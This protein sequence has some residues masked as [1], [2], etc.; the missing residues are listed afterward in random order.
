[1]A[2]RSSNGMQQG[3]G[4]PPLLQRPPSMTAPPLGGM[5]KRLTSSEHF[6]ASASDDAPL[7]GGMPPMPVPSPA[8]KP[9]VN[10]PAREGEEQTEKKAPFWSKRPYFKVPNKLKKK[11]QNARLKKIL[12]PKNATMVLHEIRPGVKYSFHEQYSKLSPHLIISS[13][14]VDGKTYLGKGLSRAYAKMNAAETVLKNMLLQKLY[15]TNYSSKVSDSDEP[16]PK[17]EP[18]SMEADTDTSE[19]TDGDDDFPWGS[20]ASFAL[21][22]LFSEWETQPSES[23]TP[24]A[25]PEEMITD[26]LAGP[27]KEVV[28]KNV[29]AA[30]KATAA[31]MKKVPD[32]PTER[33]PVM[34][35]HQL[36]PGTQFEEVSSTGPPGD[37]TFT[38]KVVIDD[39]TFTGVGKNKKEAKKETAKAALAGAY[40]IK[41]D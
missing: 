22:K 36:R 34:L 21:Y 8:N 29:T 35:L 5:A 37:V 41:Y 40:D 20:L 19:A 31:P 28:S 6:S 26:A 33:H 11:R 30:P 38:M 2:Y 39:K 4:L 1:M 7:G 25:Q 23:V 15:K 12:Q 18:E 17:S 14:E 9:D 24:G 32:N 27:P 10:V 3:M 13:V 16:K